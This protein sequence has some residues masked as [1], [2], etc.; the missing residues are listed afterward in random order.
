M[1]QIGASTSEYV[2]CLNK[3]VSLS[4]REN[5]N[6]SPIPPSLSALPTLASQWHSFPR[7]HLYQA[8]SARRLSNL[9]NLSR[10]KGIVVM[11]SSAIAMNWT[12]YPDIVEGALDAWSA[13]PS[14][15]TCS[16]AE[17]NVTHLLPL[18]KLLVQPVINEEDHSARRR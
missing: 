10:C 15:S 5:F 9:S 17:M 14:V 6:T 11:D 4:S 3:H 13:C 7:G 16:I 1:V 8:S 18:T 12:R 2:S